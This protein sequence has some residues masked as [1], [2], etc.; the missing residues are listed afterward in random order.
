MRFLGL[1][2]VAALLTPL[3]PARAQT[4]VSRTEIRA[5]L[6]ERAEAVRNGDRDAFLATV[7]RYEEE[8][9]AAQRRWFDNLQT[10]R[11]ASYGLQVDWDE[12]GDLASA[13]LGRRYGDAERVVLPVTNE[14]YRIAGYDGGP[15]VQRSYF[16]FVER[17]GNWRIA[18]DSDVA[19]VGLI[20][21]RAPWHFGP[22]TALRSRH[23]LLLQH[24][25][26]AVGCPVLGAAFLGL[27]EEALRRVDARWRASWS[28]RVVVYEPRSA[29][30]LSELLDVSFDT[31][32]FIAFAV[33]QDDRSQSPSRVL[34]SSDGIAGRSPDDVIAVL[35]HELAHVASRPLT[36]RS[37]PLFV[38]EGLA[39]YV[40]RGGD[41]RFVD[42]Y[43]AGAGGRA[44][45]PRDAQFTTGSRDQIFDR[46]Q[47][48]HS[49]VRFFV[50]RW[51][52]VR[53][54]RFYRSLG[55]L[56][57]GLGTANYHLG[58]ALEKA[59]GLDFRAFVR[60]WADTIEP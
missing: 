27:A 3:V 15:V 52:F 53:F 59:T 51:G 11:L 37:T 35:S 18:S 46:Y 9:V 39:E 60:R 24:P 19:D 56:S 45:I 31:T 55:R 4:G 54:L 23:I 8:F 41:A 16:T 28:R 34:V 48:A 49:A 12:M 42:S 14:R 10:V 50:R 1:L 17:D 13:S 7:A 2:L 29:G 58:R 33:T 38:E 25:C 32:N 6:I 47:A 30:E 22:L 5:L 40:G 36:G 21:E 57:E 26:D 43:E 44:R 20:S